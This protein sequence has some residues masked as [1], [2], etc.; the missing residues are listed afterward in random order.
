[1]R[2]DKTQRSWLIT[3][4]MIT[5]I[6]S[7]GYIFY[8]NTIPGGPDG[9]SVIGL[10]YGFLGTAMIL[11]AGFLGGRK[12]LILLRVGSLSWWMR[13]HLWLGALSLPMIL[14]HAAFSFGGLLTS[15]LMWLLFIIIVSGVVGA[16]IQHALP[17]VMT[18]QVNQEHTHEQSNKMR[19]GL[20]L[21]AYELVASVCGP[22]EEASYERTELESFTGTPPREPKKVDPVEGGAAIKAVYI[23]TILPYLHNPR[24]GSATLSSM[25]RATML[26]DNLKPGVDPSKHDVIDDLANVCSE[27]RQQTRQIR[28]HRILHGWL[29]LHIPLS[30]A[31]MVL[32]LVHA[33]MALYY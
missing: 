26:F 13:G 24:N 33:V 30:M 20:R 12:K 27:L 9:G 28:L 16:I 15:T 21:D 7:V 17:G 3:T 25:V 4:V 23:H 2:F 31:L 29:L 11:F 32:M 19:W 8:A 14:F 6:S 5:V 18:D 1:M 22:L 10:V